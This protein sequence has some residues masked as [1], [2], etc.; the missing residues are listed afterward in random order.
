MQ[1]F[2]NRSKMKMNESVMI[3]LVSQISANQQTAD[4]HNL[5][6]EIQNTCFNILKHSF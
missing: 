1:T 6:T 4:Q 2:N 5:T 3:K